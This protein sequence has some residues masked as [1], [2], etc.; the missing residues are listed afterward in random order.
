MADLDGFHTPPPPEKGKVVLYTNETSTP[1]TMTHQVGSSL[2]EVAHELG[3]LYSPIKKT[4]SSLYVREDDTWAM[5]GRF[6]NAIRSHEILPWTEDSKGVA[7][8]SLK[9]DLQ[10]SNT[11]TTNQSLAPS[12][13]SMST[14]SSALTSSGLTM[15]QQQIVELLNISPSLTIRSKSV[16]LRLSYAKY[17]G[18]LKAQDDMRRMIA[19]G[20]WTLGKV[21]METIH[22]IFISRSVWHGTYCKLFPKAMCHPHL[23]RW[24]ENK[25]D[26][27]PSHEIFGVSKQCYSFKDLGDLLGSLEVKR[28]RSRESSED[29]GSHKKRK[30]SKHSHKDSSM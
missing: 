9:A 1:F 12:L 23:V 21:S 30:K 11:P 7:S 19:D 15:E 18:A 14:H 8:V 13:P 28:K 20:T 6:S 22:G 16:D 10:V 29:R 3:N 5:K 4:N 25:R 27:L 17:L 24:L 2:S 26:A